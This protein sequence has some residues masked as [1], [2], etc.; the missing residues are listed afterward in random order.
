MTFAAATCTCSKATT[1]YWWQSM[2]GGSKMAVT[3]SWKG[4]SSIINIGIIMIIIS[5]CSRSTP[6]MLGFTCSPHCTSLQHDLLPV[7]LY[8]ATRIIAVVTSCM[9]ICGEDSDCC[10][11]HPLRLSVAATAAELLLCI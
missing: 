5:I 3:A 9:L 11:W 1:V 7:M 10:C 6:G 2:T 4:S 8:G